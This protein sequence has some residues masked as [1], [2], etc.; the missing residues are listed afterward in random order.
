MGL[1]MCLNKKSKTVCP[2]CGQEIKNSITTEEVAYWRK[3]NA[4]HKWFE[5]NC[6]DGNIENCTDYYVSKE[7]LEELLNICKRVNAASKLVQG[8]VSDGYR[9]KDGKEVPMYRIGMVIEDPSVAQELLPTQDGFFFGNTSYDE[10]YLENIRD[11][12]KK[13]AEILETTDFDHEY[14]EYYAWW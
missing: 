10:E 12:I 14:I 9:F 2:H 8:K 1:D 13:I 7:Q 3:A 11:T 4:I 5:D 6:A